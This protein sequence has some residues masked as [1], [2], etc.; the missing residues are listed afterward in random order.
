[1]RGKVLERGACFDNFA[2]RCRAD[3]VSLGV[4]IRQEEEE[5]RVLGFVFAY[6]K[7]RGFL[8]A[9]ALRRSAR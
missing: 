7:P 6:Y 3:D 2:G 9:R 1:M 8:R 5:M 4:G